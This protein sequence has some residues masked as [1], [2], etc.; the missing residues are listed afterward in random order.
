MSFTSGSM[1]G[2]TLEAA[3]ISYLIQ[4]KEHL[5]KTIA[6]GRKTMPNLMM[7]GALKYWIDEKNKA[8]DADFTDVEREA[9]RASLDE[10]R[11]P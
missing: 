11:A 9:A 10:V 2:Q 4:S 5:E 6:G 7:L 3:P 1:K 8:V